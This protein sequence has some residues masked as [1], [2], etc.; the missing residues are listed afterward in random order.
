MLFKERL[1]Y[2]KT[3]HKSVFL[4]LSSILMFTLAAGC[5][6]ATAIDSGIPFDDISNSYAQSQITDLYNK[7]IISGTGYRTFEPTKSITRAEFVTMVNRLLNLKPVMNDIPSFGDVPRDAW[8][9]GWVQSGINLN[10][11]QGTSNYGFEPQK[12]ISRE[13]AATMIVRAL[14]QQAGSSSPA[15]LPFRDNGSVSNWAIPYVNEISKLALMTGDAGNFRPNDSITRQ[16]T[17][18]VF[19]RVLQNAK[20]ANQLASVHTASIQLGWQYGDTTQ[21]FIDRIG[22]T[23]INTVV[24]R[25]FFIE[26][27]DTVS[28]HTD[29]ALLTWTAQ[30]RIDVW[31]MLGNHSNADW[32]DRILS[33]AQK[34]T[35]VIQ[36]VTAY[37]QKYQLAGINMDFENVYIKDKD[38]LTTFVADLATALH[39]MNRKLSVDVS[40]DTGTDWTNAINYQAIGQSADYVIMMGY[41]EH[42]G[43]SPQAGSVSSLPWYQKSLDKLLTVVPSAKTI[44]AL[45]FYTRDWTLGATVSSEDLTLVEQGNRLSMTNASWLWDSTSGQYVATYVSN[46]TAHEIWTEDS[47]SLSLKY[48]MAANRG[49]AGFAYWYID[50]E[51]TDVWAALSNAAKYAS[52]NFQ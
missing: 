43:G 17:A 7:N 29:P 18:V 12:T 28:D 51:T 47:R 25:W 27:S 20:W 49:V 50:A 24:P 45:P 42:W 26:S 9:Y 15:D 41:D 8:F 16:E 36:Q 4:F 22:Q 11:V 40:P 44:A 10:F 2:L 48:A 31:A 14:K 38:A 30:N 52:Y 3:I 1:T 23:S 32:T 37:V 39:G 35:A 5:A 21:Q 6:K 33:D 19:D 13:E 34:R 46:W